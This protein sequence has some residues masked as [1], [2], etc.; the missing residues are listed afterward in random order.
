MTTDDNKR[1]EVSGGW[2]ALTPAL[3]WGRG[4]IVVSRSAKQA[5][6]EISSD[7]LCCSLS[8]GERVRARADVSINIEVRH[9]AFGFYN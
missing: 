1:I 3:S 4:R 6:L 8:P 2:S 7:D 5:R 9:S